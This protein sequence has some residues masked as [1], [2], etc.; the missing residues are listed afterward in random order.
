MAKTTTHC[1]PA[2]ASAIT[3]INYLPHNKKHLI[4]N[5]LK[6]RRNIDIFMLA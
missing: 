1:E 2:K 6:Q 4:I 5:A 3:I